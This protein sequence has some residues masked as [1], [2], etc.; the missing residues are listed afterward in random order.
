V[1]C[2]T[3]PHA[4]VPFS[5]VLETAYIPDAARVIAAVRSIL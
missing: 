2:V 1:K 4:P 3:G 5:R